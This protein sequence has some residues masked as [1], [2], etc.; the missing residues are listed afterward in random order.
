MKSSAL[1]NKVILVIVSDK[2]SHLNLVFVC[3]VLGVFDVNFIGVNK[4]LVTSL[5]RY[6]FISLTNLT[7]RKNE[8]ISSY[9]FTI[10]RSVL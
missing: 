5:K 4:E 6:Y 10:S 9:Q 8:V 7:M 2:K 3:R 1:E